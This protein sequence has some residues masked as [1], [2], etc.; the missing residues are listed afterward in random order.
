M[1]APL[2]LMLHPCV[3]WTEAP[4]WVTR[5]FQEHTDLGYFQELGCLFS[6][7]LQGSQ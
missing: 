6:S 7:I 3:Q 5:G 4:F 1:R 2:Y